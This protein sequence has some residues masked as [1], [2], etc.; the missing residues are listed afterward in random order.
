MIPAKP[1]VG[2]YRFRMIGGGLQLQITGA[3]DLPNVL[4]LD[5]A[6]WAMTGIDV[7]ALRMDRR[8]LEFVDHD[9]DGKIRTDEVKAA[10]KFV[11]DNFRD[12]QGVTQRSPFLRVSA[13]NPQA[14]DGAALISCAQLLLTNL[15]R[16]ADGVLS[17]E[18][19]R[20]AKSVTSFA[21][22]NGDGI[23]SCENELS[24]DIIELINLIMASGRKS[25]DRS[26][27][28]GVSLADVEGFEA[29][30]QRH[31]ALLDAAENDPSIMLYG[32][33][34]GALY[35]L[36]SECE[37]LIDSYFLNSAAG[38]FLFA[39]P[40]R[41]EKKEFSADLMDSGQVREVLTQAAAALPGDPEELDFD[42]PLNPLYADKLQQLRNSPVLAGAMTG[43]ILRKSS[44]MAV[45][46]AMAPFAAWQA[47][48]LVTGGLEKFSEDD[49]RKAAGAPFGK[50]KELIAADLSFAP[51]ISAGETLLK[52]VLCQQYMIEFLNNFT[53][54]PDLFNGHH[55]SSLQM[56]KLIMD[57]RHFT[58]TVKVK[59]IAEHKR[60]IKSSNICVIYVDISRQNGAK[61]DTQLLAAA[62]T[63]GTMRSLFVGKRGIFFD[64][65]GV[66]YDAVIR[67]IAEQPVSI[68]E[69][70]KTPFYNFADFLSKQTEKIFNSRNAAMQKNLTAELNKSQLASVPKVPAGSTAAP[71][72]APA[73]PGTGGNMSMMLMTG[74]IGVAALGSSVAF[75]A[76]SLQNVSFAAVLAVVTG[77]IVIFGGPS[78]II[79]LCK[80]FRRNL[81]RFLESCGCA[82]NRPMRMSRKMGSIFTFTPRRP[83]GEVSL[84]DPVDVFQPAVRRFPWKKM[85]TVFLILAVGA[86]CGIA[87]AW[88]HIHYLKNHA[89]APVKTEVKAEVKIESAAKTKTETAKVEKAAVPVE[90]E[91]VTEKGK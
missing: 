53:S 88:A 54:L 46:A 49:L 25:C 42:G 57:G 45:K 75:I 55:P 70:F 5:E 77:I 2:N 12:L 91:K 24:P 8:F 21:R 1:P 60:I 90:A 81:S 68:G 19:I 66:I 56:G 73:A 3:E 48:M 30:L 51:V 17:A 43:A 14:P 87:F 18:D 34:S 82:V 69:A 52:M 83:R 80:I 78:V 86:L 23:I 62:V 16:P 85:V 39:D 40:G 38:R 58:L 44:W 36:F 72:T 7:D 71:V 59:N 15:D 6:H 26:G 22:R 28:D 27:N 33:K 65:D 31:L 76:K 79:A 32:E 41:Q 4:A 20:N 64:T 84:I 10:V 63:S 35:Q 67:D 89:A 50:L 61:Q 47:E 37:K 29:A 74:G 11:L 9:H 13:I